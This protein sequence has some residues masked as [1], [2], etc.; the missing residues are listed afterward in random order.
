MKY[1]LCGSLKK[2]LNKKI[3]IVLFIAFTALNT[4]A[5]NN[6]ISWT[7]SYKAI[8]STE[9]EVIINGIVDKGWHTYSQEKND[10]VP[11]PTLISFKEN[12]DYKLSGKAVESNAHEEFDATLNEK[13]FVFTEK[14][15][16]KQKI[17]ITGKSPQTIAFKVEYICCDNTMCLP[18]TTVDLSVKTQ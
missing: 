2:I 15:E 9:G 17:N 11:F 18:P 8:S 14:A 3:V 6:H 5:Q 16:F 4:Y 10:A 1:I 13:L 7:A 12:K